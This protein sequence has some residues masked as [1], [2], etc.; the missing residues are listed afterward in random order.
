MQPQTQP[1]LTPEEYLA[2]E[3]Q[4]ARRH[5]YLQ[6][7]VLAMAGASERHNTVVV[8]TATLLVTQLRGRQCKAYASDMR[9]KV[10][11]T[12]LY[13]YPDLVV[14]CGAP[15]FDDAHQD[16]L[17][18]PTLIAEVLSES[19]EAYDRGQKFAHYRSLPS[20]SDYLLISQD[21]PSI[22]HFQRQPGQQWL[23]TEV[24]GLDAVAFVPTITCKLSLAEVYN[25]VAFPAT[26]PGHARL[27]VIKEPA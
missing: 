15:Q 14:V 8:N 19:T 21:R 7:Q 17:L 24:T 26:P 25:K 16:T 10:S 23:L 11:A 1:Y 6:G 18:N 4:A 20:L 12:G 5:E 22:E 13:T 2:L 3:R 27:T 9:V